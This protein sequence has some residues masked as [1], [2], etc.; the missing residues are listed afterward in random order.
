M[1]ILIDQII[2]FFGE[3]LKLNIILKNNLSNYNSKMYYLY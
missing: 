3:K 2:L 1:I